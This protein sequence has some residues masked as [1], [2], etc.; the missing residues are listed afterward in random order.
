M[1]SQQPGFA[2]RASCFCAGKGDLAEQG[3]E[4]LRRREDFLEAKGLSRREVPML[5]AN[6]QVL[7][8]RSLHRCC[9]RLVAG[10][11]AAKHEPLVEGRDVML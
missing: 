11:S 1:Q 3:S 7:M 5:I 9:L 6:G 4:A 8:P 2:P 10:A